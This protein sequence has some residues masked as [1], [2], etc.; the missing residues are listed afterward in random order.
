ML[1]LRLQLDRP[2]C[3]YLLGK[4][5]LGLGGLEIPFPFLF[6]PRTHGIPHFC[7]MRS[8]LEPQDYRR[9]QISFF[10]GLSDIL[11]RRQKLE[12]FRY[13]FKLYLAW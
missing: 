12:T 8:E 6:P 13:T 2:T 9:N 10:E 7:H 4:F 5:L 11:C 1:N 3:N